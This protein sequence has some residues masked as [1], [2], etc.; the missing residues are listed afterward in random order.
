MSNLER[1]V[2]SNTSALIKAALAHVQFETIHPFLDGNGRIGRLLITLV[3]CHDGVLREEIQ[4]GVLYRFAVNPVQSAGI[5]L[6]LRRVACRPP[7]P[8]SFPLE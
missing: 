5:E 7:P 6:Q 3:L 1:F 8:S 4:P 2:H